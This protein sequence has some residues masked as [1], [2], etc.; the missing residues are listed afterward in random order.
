M[1]TLLSLVGPG[2]KKVQKKK[3]EA[4]R[5]LKKE[6]P[7]FTESPKMC[8][9][10]APECP[11]YVTYVSILWVKSAPVRGRRVLFEK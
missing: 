3:W 10:H 6:E 11:I 7:P 9:W 2:K 1:D 8:G 5:R 4:K